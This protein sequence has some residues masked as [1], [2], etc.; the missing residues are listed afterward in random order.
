MS[1]FGWVPDMVETMD[2]SSPA[3]TRRSDVARH[4][5][6]LIA[7][8]TE[9]FTRNPEASMGDIARAA[10]L[11]RATVYRHFANRE[12]LEAAIRS[13]ALDRASGALADCR[14]DDGTAVEVLG[15]V[16]RALSAQAMSLRFMVLQAPDSDP[17]FLARRA[18]VLSP[19]ADVVRRG[20]RE[21]LL[22]D[23]LSPEWIVT[24]MASLLVAAVRAA[25][26]P[27]VEVAELV[28]RT[29]MF[30]VAK[31]AGD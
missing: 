19:L 28:H 24:T 22:D 14:L 31:P 30:G 20:Q 25:P 17:E 6:M 4:R 21:G 15:R 3:P 12:A 2:A 27:D 10:E 18:Q 5:E 1:R 23:R 16:I 9:E 8:A 11:T 7:A 29:L 26:S 13:D